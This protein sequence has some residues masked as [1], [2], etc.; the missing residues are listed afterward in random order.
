MVVLVRHRLL[1]SGRDIAQL[2]VRF[3]LVLLLVR[4]G[5]GLLAFLLIKLVLVL[6]MLLALVGHRL[7]NSRCR[8]DEALQ[9]TGLLLD[10]LLEVVLGGL[11]HLHL[12]LGCSHLGEELVER[13]LIL[14]HVLGSQARVR[15]G[16]LQIVDHHGFLLCLE[17]GLLEF[18][19]LLLVEHVPDDLLGFA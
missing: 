15:C 12:L 19:L 1:L 5:V 2:D 13:G 6:L 16:L 7:S 8:L 14:L 10:Y 4:R 17:H 3:L 18:C 11:L 9:G